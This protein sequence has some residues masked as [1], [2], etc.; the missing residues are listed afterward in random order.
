MAE[1][2]KLLELDIDV[3]QLVKNTTDARTS[4]EK[5]K[6]EVSL[7]KKDT[8]GM[9][10]KFN[11]IASSPAAE[12]VFDRKGYLADLKAQEFSKVEALAAIKNKFNK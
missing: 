8:E 12:K 3:N 1:K 4:V 6:E 7:L 5:L 2:I 9:E 11:K 10:E